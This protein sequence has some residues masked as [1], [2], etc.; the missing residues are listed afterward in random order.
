VVFIG[1]TGKYLHYSD[2]RGFTV[3][4]GL[5][6]RPAQFLSL[7]AVGYNLTNPGNSAPQAVGGGACLSLVPGLLLLVD[8]VLERVSKESTNPQETRSSAYYVMGGGEYLARTVAVRL[9]GGWD[10]LNRNGYLSGGLSF[11]SGVGALDVSARQDISGD[12]KG[13][14]VGVSARLFV[15]AP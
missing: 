13:T 2:A 14:F 12:R 9:G 1:V 8:S 4:T 3:D 15:P 6:I 5:T 10:G 11:V 7:A